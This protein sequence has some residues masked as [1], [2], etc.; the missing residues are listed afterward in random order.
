MNTLLFLLQVTFLVLVA[1]IALYHGVWARAIYRM[2]A[3][4]G[5]GLSRFAKRLLSMNVFLIF[6]LT[7]ICMVVMAFNFLLGV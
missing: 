6:S 3:Q 4:L 7:T 5:M 2:E 1:I